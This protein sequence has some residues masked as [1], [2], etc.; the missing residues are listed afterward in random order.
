[1]RFRFTIRDLLWQTVVAA[2][3]TTW[4]LDRRNLCRKIDTVQ[5]ALWISEHSI[6]S[7]DSY[8]SYVASNNSLIATP[9]NLK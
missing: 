3:A 4:W 2:M 5:N 6:H 8:Q 1:M 7:V 9:T